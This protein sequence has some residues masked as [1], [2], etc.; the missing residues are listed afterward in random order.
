MSV[1]AFSLRLESIGC[2]S[3]HLPHPNDS[4]AKQ[5]QLLS[6]ATEMLEGVPNDDVSASR[7]IAS[8]L[9]SIKKTSLF[10]P[11]FHRVRRLLE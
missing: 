6:H 2:I 5:S 11:V 1:S 10:S 3:A 7:M 8:T 9:S 4:S